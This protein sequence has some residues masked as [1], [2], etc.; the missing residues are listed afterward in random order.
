MNPA[1]PPITLREKLIFGSGDIFIG[2]SQVIMAFYYLRFLTDVVQIS[3]ALAGTVVLVSKVW[4]AISDP[5]MGV[6]TDNTRT[7]WGRRKPYFVLAF[8]GIITSFIALWY[9]VSFDTELKKFAY[10][11][12]TYIY[13][14][15]IATVCLVPYSSMSSEI[16]TDYEERNNINGIRLFFSQ[17][18]SLLAAVLPLTIVEMFDDPTA[19]WLAMAVIF[20]L[21]YAVPWLMMFVFT[22]ERVP[23]SDERSQFSLASFLRP[24]EVRTFRKL[25]VM[26]FLAY[27]SM[28]VVA[29]VF[30]Y[31]MYYYLDRKDEA[32]LVIGTMLVTQILLIPAVV[33]LANRFGKA[34][35]YRYSI[36]L[37]LLGAC[38]MAAY[39]P[40]WPDYA[41]YLVAAV[42]G[43][44][45]VGCVVMPWSIFP[46]VTDV[47]ELRFGKRI[48]GSFSGVMTFSR[49]FSGAI[50]IFAV[51]VILE[52]SGY[53][54]PVREMRE[55]RY[56]EILQVQPDSVITALQLIV[57]LVPI[58]LLVPAFLAAR[59]YPL[60]KLT[61]NSL[62]R[63]LEFQRGEKSDSNLSDDELE[64]MR[65]LLI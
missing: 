44:G 53:L 28:D 12:A 9:P 22:H 41:I 6:I 60:D 62:R 13:F 56:T 18:S 21:F 36:V 35:V 46:D 26:Y 51:G 10:V 16:S 23:M 20:S 15:T 3:P 63:Y 31:Y 5:V 30:Q 19:G 65:R 64:A 58:A 24:F 8:F 45:V 32:D 25:L 11:L 38:L 17:L 27:L 4:D 42:V 7:R 33:T 29:A 57:F 34:T 61:H 55:G 54:P 48:A 52:V 40:D 43:S 14:S 39:R 37:W 1:P 47:G 49:K 59:T 50:G 2:G